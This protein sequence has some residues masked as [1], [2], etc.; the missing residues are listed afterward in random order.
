[1]EKT[2]LVAFF[3]QF[4][5]SA[6]ASDAVVNKF[7]GTSAVGEG[8][9]AQLD[10]QYI[11]G[12]APGVKTDF[13]EQMN[14]DFCADLKNWTTILLADSD[15]PLVHSV[16]YGWQGNLT[17]IGCKGTRTSHGAFE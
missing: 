5:P 14:M 6:P 7:V 2:D 11:M 13:Y 1:M 10:I 3:K 17:Q 15:A 16:S 9:E 4:V 12:V 8:I